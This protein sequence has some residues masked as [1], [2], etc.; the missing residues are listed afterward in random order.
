MVWD[1]PVGWGAVGYC[2]CLVN[3]RLEAALTGSQDDCLH[4]VAARFPACQS[5]RHPA[6]N[7]YSVPLPPA[8]TL[9][10]FPACALAVLRVESACD[11]R[12]SQRHG[13]FDRGAVR[14]GN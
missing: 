8:D 7:R 4:G 1:G 9:T 10:H 6:A 13:H 11:R 5:G 12:I 2:I 3:T 14:F